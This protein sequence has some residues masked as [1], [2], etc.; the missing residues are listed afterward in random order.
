MYEVIPNKMKD[1]CVYPKGIQKLFSQYDF[2]VKYYTGNINALKN[3]VNKGNPIIVMIRTYIG[4]NWLHYV[5]V[6]GY[7]QLPIT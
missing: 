1:G 3:E 6:V 7:G 4:E 5:L 2:H